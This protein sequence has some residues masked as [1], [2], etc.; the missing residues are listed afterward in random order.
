MLT[1]VINSL[2]IQYHVLAGKHSY[3]VQETAAV[4]W[5]QDAAPDVRTNH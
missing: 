3:N 5:P 2:I 1:F 4:F